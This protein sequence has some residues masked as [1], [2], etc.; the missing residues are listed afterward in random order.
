[1]EVDLQ[2]LQ[3]EHEE[4][5]GE[6]RGFTDKAKKTSCEVKPNRLRHERHCAMTHQTN[7]VTNLVGFF[8]GIIMSA[9]TSGGGAASGAGA[10]AA[11]GESEERTGGPDQR[12][13]W[14]TGG[15]RADG[16]EGRKEDYSEVGGKG[17][18]SQ[19]CMDLYYDVIFVPHS[20]N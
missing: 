7:V 15:G 10:H 18:D 17:M 5:L 2:T 13:E 8:F 11:P 16:S 6:M 3:Q 9:G 1:M 12:H 14:P 19:T 4:L 20:L